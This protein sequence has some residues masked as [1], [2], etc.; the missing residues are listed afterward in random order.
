MAQV[1]KRPGNFLQK[2]GTWYLVATIASLLAAAILALAFHPLAGLAPLPLLVSAASR[3]ARYVKGLTGE[4]QV[5]EALAALDDSYYVVHD[6][7]I[8]RANIDHIVL[9]PNGVFVLETKNFSGR[10]TCYHDR[11]W[12]ARRGSGSRGRQ[13]RSPGHQA[14]TNAT[15]VRQRIREFERTLLKGFPR[16]QWVH[17][18]VVLPHPEVE[19]IVNS[20]GVPVLRVGELV[21]HIRAA[22][23]PAKLP[24]ALLTKIGFA[25][26]G[27]APGE[28]LG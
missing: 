16:V 19:V 2:R 27:M 22:P 3:Y 12:V 26:M 7:K 18:V 10:V 5:G 21:A 13:I 23:L 17:A 25:L 28:Q 6:A 20:P 1:M 15:K 4:R 14:N 24:A 9:G 8:P 11:W